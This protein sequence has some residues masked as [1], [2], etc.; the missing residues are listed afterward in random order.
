MQQHF[1]TGEPCAPV[2][3]CAASVEL[4]VPANVVAAG[5]VCS[6]N[7]SDFPIRPACGANEPLAMA[8]VPAQVYR[9][10]FC[11]CEALS[12]GT[13]FPELVSRWQRRNCDEV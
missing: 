11:P 5:E 13:L 9:V 3:C 8:Y 12:H 1:T 10:G 4:V 7:V 6:G 2:A